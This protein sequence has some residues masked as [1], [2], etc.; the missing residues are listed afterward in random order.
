MAI[1]S[2]IMGFSQYYGYRNFKHDITM[3]EAM[4]A[5]YKLLIKALN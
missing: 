5:S 4:A 3:E 1:S 2:A